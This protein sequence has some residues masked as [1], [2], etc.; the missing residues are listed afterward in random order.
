VII[1]GTSNTNGTTQLIGVPICPDLL[2]Y[3]RIGEADNLRG[4]VVRCFF[5]LMRA[6]PS[7]Y[8]G[9]GCI[10][11][12]GSTCLTPSD[13]PARGSRKKLEKLSG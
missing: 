12:P 8:R 9:G 11:S 5:W 7:L 3:D 13:L 6:W 4:R 2:D 10:S 1:T